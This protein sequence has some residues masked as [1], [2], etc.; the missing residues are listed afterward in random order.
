MADDY[1]YFGSG[2]TGYAH[3]VAASG[4]DKIPKGGGGNNGG[5]LPKIGCFGSTMIFLF[6]CF[7][8]SLFD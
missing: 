2:D 6:I 4:E 1:G 5:G 7:I 3:Y 8:I